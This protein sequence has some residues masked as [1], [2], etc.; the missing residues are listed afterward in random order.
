M[1]FTVSLR[2]GR[3]DQKVHRDEEQKE[4]CR[5][6]MDLEASPERKSKNNKQKRSLGVFEFIY[7]SISHVCMQLLRQL[8]Q[9]LDCSNG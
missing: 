6:R 9:R 3:A 2:A 1:A 5:R 8:P 4:L 7:Y